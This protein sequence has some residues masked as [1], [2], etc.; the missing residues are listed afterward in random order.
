MNPRQIIAA[1]RVLEEKLE[2]DGAYVS[3]ATCY[4]ARI[5]IAAALAVAGE[6]EGE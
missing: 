1:L 6:G 4:H 5:Y 3:A 2:L